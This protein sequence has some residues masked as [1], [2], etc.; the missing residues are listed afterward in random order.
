MRVLLAV[1]WFLRY[2]SEQALGLREAGAEVRVLCRDHLHEFGGERAEWEAAIGAMK[3]GGV[4]VEVVCGRASSSRAA[5]S[6]GRLRRRLRRWDPDIVHAHPNHDPW[7]LALTRRRPTVLTVHDP[8]PHPGQPR[9]FAVK[10]RL[11]R[12]WLDR[13][14][15]YVVHGERLRRTLERRLGNG[16]PVAVIPHGARPAPAPLAVPT[17]RDVLLLGRLEP[18]KGVAV[19]VAAMRRVWASRPDVRLTVAGRG[20]AEGEVPDDPR[21]R[22]L[23]RYVPEREVARLFAE[24]SLV[25]APYTEA[26]QSGVVSLAVARGIPCVVTDVGALPELAVE[27]GLVAAPDDPE[28]L[29]RAVLAHVDHGVELRRRVYAFAAA[30]LAWPV[31]GGRCLELYREVLAE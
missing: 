31:V 5:R 20:P 17:R 26:S 24:A 28:D 2:G 1:D 19:L 13:A 10:R 16:R 30:R 9:L 6:L 3:A 8:L 29:A 15:G 25:A 7:L 18:Y 12:A 23:T 11:D 4:G 22:R 27:P 21:I 14:A